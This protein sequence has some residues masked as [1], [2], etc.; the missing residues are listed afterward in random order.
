MPPR[1]PNTKSQ[2][3]RFLD[4]AQKW[5]WLGA[6]ADAL[7][8]VDKKDEVG[9]IQEVVARFEKDKKLYR[10]DVTTWLRATG[11]MIRKSDNGTMYT[12]AVGTVLL[13]HFIRSRYSEQH[14]AF[15]FVFGFAQSLYTHLFR[16]SKGF[17]NTIKAASAYLR[18]TFQKNDPIVLFF[19]KQKY[20]IGGDTEDADDNGNNN[21]DVDV[22][23]E[24]GKTICLMFFLFAGMNQEK[25]WNAWYNDSDERT[26]RK[27]V[28]Y[29]WIDKA[30]YG[31]HLEPSDTAT[32][33]FHK[34]NQF[35][36][37]MKTT[38]FIIHKHSLRWTC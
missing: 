12:K 35:T 5:I 15:T 11:E 14:S 2:P 24:K 28:V 3:P 38:A 31:K 1:K 37:E 34:R 18:L 20:D 32:G 33:M 13:F 19:N 9:D 7:A 10:K 26:R 30:N 25:L 27:V 21:K 23:A 6:V 4:D 36:S 17:E 16:T 8:T 22:V 29:W